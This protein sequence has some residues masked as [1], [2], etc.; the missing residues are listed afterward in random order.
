MEAAGKFT[1]VIRTGKSKRHTTLMHLSSLQ[2][3]DLMD[4]DRQVT[5][6][7]SACRDRTDLSYDYYVL[8]Q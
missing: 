6:K 3:S 4:L 7:L 2:S 1:P 8:A 5:L